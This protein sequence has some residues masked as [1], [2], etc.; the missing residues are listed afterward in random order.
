[1][2]STLYLSR[3]RFADHVVLVGGGSSWT[4]S[5]ARYADNASTSWHHPTW[6]IVSTTLAVLYSPR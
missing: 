3:G 4:C 5:N 6:S 2:S 1:M